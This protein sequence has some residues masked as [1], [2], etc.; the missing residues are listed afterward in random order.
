MSS[1]ELLFFVLLGK[2]KHEVEIP[3]RAIGYS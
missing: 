2:P 3:H 1:K